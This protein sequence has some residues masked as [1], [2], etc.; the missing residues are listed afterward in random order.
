MC[1][2]GK[3]RQNRTAVPSY[4]WQRRSEE[5]PG[6]SMMRRG[7]GWKKG[8]LPGLK[9]AD[10]LFTCC[11]SC[12]WG[13]LS[14]S[15]QSCN[16]AVEKPGGMMKTQERS[17]NI[18]AE[19]IVLKD[20]KRQ[21]EGSQSTVFIPCASAWPWIVTWLLKGHSAFTCADLLEYYHLE[22]HLDGFLSWILT[23]WIIWTAAHFCSCTPN[24]T[25]L[26]TWKIMTDAAGVHLKCS[27]DNWLRL[28]Q[29]YTVLILVATFL[30]VWKIESLK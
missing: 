13:P 5:Q 22:W 16:A 15:N 24:F 2:F 17:W 1:V 19:I 11:P 27:H 7:D 26:L 28:W 25:N 8:C 9:V 30:A 6:L 14:P 10:L 3:E 23:G 18:P 12:R 4:S 29:P 20:Y 21:Q